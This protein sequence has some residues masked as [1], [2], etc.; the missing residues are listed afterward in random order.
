M[1]FDNVGDLEKAVFQFIDE[2][3]E[4]VEQNAIEE[5]VKQLVTSVEEESGFT[6]K[7]NKI[8]EQQKVVDGAGN[9]LKVENP[10]RTLSRIDPKSGA[11][12]TLT[13][14]ED[15]WLRSNKLYGDDV[16]KRLG[17]KYTNR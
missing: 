6:N 1:K 2:L 8:F 16:L 15:R 5:S 9:P 12:I 3:K 10:G 7:A 4:E 14:E 11:E 17:F 13:A